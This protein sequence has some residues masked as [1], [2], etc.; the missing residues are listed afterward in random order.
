MAS[1]ADMARDL[2]A[3]GEGGQATRQPRQGQQ[4]LFD[5]SSAPMPFGQ[6]G[7]GQPQRAPAAPGVPQR[8]STGWSK[9]EFLSPMPGAGI[10][11]SGGGQGPQTQPPGEPVLPAPTLPPWPPSSLASM[12]QMLIGGGRAGS[13]PAAGAQM[14]PV[15]GGGLPDAGVPLP[16]VA[17]GNAF[18]TMPSR[19]GWPRGAQQQPTGIG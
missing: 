15:A 16:S 14:P 1:F 13:P 19:Y 4:G 11:Q 9:P 12:F 3:T 17:P 8:S 18:D 2:I 6:A 7:A 10:D 5:R